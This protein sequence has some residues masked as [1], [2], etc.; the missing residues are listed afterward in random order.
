MSTFKLKKGY[1]LNLQGGITTSTV[2]TAPAPRQC[3]VV[4]DD[5]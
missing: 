5:F 2:A 1:N 4:P 3:A